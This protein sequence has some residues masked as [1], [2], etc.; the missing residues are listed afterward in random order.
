MISKFTGYLN[1]LINFINNSY[2]P[3]VQLL[4]NAYSDYRQ[5]GKGTG[6]LIAFGVFDLDNTSNPNRLLKRGVVYSTNPT[7]VQTVSNCRRRARSIRRNWKRT[8]KR[9]DSLSRPARL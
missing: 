6:N 2:V 9:T 1:T 7:S 3:D 8:S 5:I 4:A